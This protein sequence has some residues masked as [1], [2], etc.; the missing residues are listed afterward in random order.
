M[1][2]TGDNVIAD[3]VKLREA[4][5]SLRTCS[6][7]IQKNI[8]NLEAV[9]RDISLAYQSEASDIFQTKLKKLSDNWS[10]A[11]NELDQKLN[12]NLDDLA[13]SYEDAIKKANAAVEELE[14]EFIMQ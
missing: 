14:S 1:S 8:T 10:A 4:L 6:S 9:Q 13:L 11:K 12:K 5:E 2:T 3:P 7:N